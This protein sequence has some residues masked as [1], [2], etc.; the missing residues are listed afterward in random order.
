ML[1][2]VEC[3]LKGIC[4]PWATRE[5]RAPHS[6]P[7]PGALP[8]LSVF[9]LTCEPPGCSPKDSA[10]GAAAA[11][12]AAAAAG[13][14]DLRKTEGTPRVR[15][16]RQPARS[17]GTFPLRQNF[18]SGEVG[19]EGRGGRAGGGR[20]AQRQCPAG[21]RLGAGLGSSRPAGARLRLQPAP[22]GTQAAPPER[23]TGAGAQAGAAR[24]KQ[25]QSPHAGGRLVAAR[26]APNFISAKVTII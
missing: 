4:K 25:Q 2:L 5:V 18:G 24:G 26:G 23:G 1:E 16:R 9:L 15:S 19:G 14:L 17:P 11:A 6:Q 22:L 20:G 13:R 10:A 21:G 8:S 3:K 12:A 7:F